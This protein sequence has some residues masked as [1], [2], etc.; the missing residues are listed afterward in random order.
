MK[1]ASLRRVPIAFIAGAL[2]LAACSSSADTT[3]PTPSTTV[4]AAID[5]AIVTGYPTDVDQ[6]SP[7]VIS[8]VGPAPIP[9][10]G[11]DNKV[12]MVYELQVLNYSPRPAVLTKL[13]TVTG[14]PEGDVVASVEG[15][16]LADRTMLVV[17]TALNASGDI[18]PGRTALILVDDTYDAKADVPETF[19][20]RLTASFG[21]VVD[22]LA[23]GSLF[24]EGSVTQ[25][26][27]PVSVG[28]GSPVVIGPPLAGGD[29][30]AGGAC[31]IL[32]A[33]RGAM[34]PIGGRV[35][36]AERYAIDWIKFGP[37]ADAS[38][39]PAGPPSFLEDPTSNED[40]YAYGEPLLAV[41]DGTVIQVVEG[42]EDAVPP[43]P[44]RD[45][46]ITQMPGNSVT[47]DIG[48]GA[49]ALYAH[50]APGSSTVK[51]GDK[52]TRGQVIGRLGNSGNS[53]EAH[54]HFQISSSAASLTGNNLPFEIDTL[55]LV[56][57]WNN[58]TSTWELDRAAAGP[59]TNQL[60]LNQSA[61][62]FPDLP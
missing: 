29:W 3:A 40:Y 59:R 62:T 48:G 23:G 45:L 8:T 55:T 24:V 5:N 37:G 7:L 51:A 20:H 21:P 22:G 49:F 34:L 11:T 53:H 28:T 12:H 44:P 42:I 52:V 58:S 17:D 27:G 50:V 60:P 16:A 26:G 30:V 46:T 1:E 35:N 33:H 2:L 47:I 25:F 41:A 6:T 31:C 19:S 13:E 39:S 36:P 38:D 9:V 61:V 18:P 10:T 14:G 43:T 15:A 57:N 54:L 32:S 4:P 56:G